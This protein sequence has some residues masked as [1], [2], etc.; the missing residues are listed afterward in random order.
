MG[1]SATFCNAIY[2]DCFVLLLFVKYFEA[3]LRE[4]RR[5][6]K[7]SIYRGSSYALYIIAVLSLSSSFLS[8]PW[9]LIRTFQYL[10]A[11]VRAL[12]REK[13]TLCQARVALST[14]ET[15]YVEILVLH[16]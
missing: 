13:A 6:A 16:S 7:K 10:R 5:K 4:T 15:P 8:S 2:R 1:I 14:L 12:A 11:V 3:K 9:F